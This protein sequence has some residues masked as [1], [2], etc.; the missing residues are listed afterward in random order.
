MYPESLYLKPSL[1]LLEFRVL[2][3]CAYRLQDGYVR[4][5]VPA[6]PLDTTHALNAKQILETGL[7]ISAQETIHDFAAIS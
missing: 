6:Q 7:A 4:F 1:D 3:K 5:C 2:A